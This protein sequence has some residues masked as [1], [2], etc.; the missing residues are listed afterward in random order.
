MLVR[1][2][3]PAYP[4]FRYAKRWP[5]VDPA[6]A[7]VA[8]GALFASL[9]IIGSIRDDTFMLS[10]PNVGLIQHPGIW[11]F[12][13]GQV[14]LPFLVR[15]AVR[16]FQKLPELPDKAL[17]AHYTKVRFASQLE[18]LGIWL[19][20][21]SNGSRIVYGLLTTLGACAWAWNTYSNQR[22]E[23]VGFDFWDSNRHLWGFSVT[24]FY[25]GYF[26]FG[27]LPCVAHIQIGLLF[28]MRRLIRDANRRRGLIME[29]YHSDGAGGLSVFIDTALNP[30]VPTVFIASM[31]SLSAV[32]VH[33]RYDITT[34]SGLTLACLA[35]ILMYLMPATTLRNAIKREKRRQLRKIARLQQKLY[36]EVTTP[37]TRD[38][39]L[40]VAES[41]E[42]IMGLTS[43][44]ERV[45]MLPEW[46]QL[47]R[48]FRLVVL[49][50]G[51]PVV[52]WAGEKGLTK[53]LAAGGM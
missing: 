8:I 35:F 28:A 12:L 47:H 7:N 25:K 53:L 43:V 3:L 14:W 16:Q 44:V 1:D 48:T 42:T 51:S 38:S 21:E 23:T 24:R 10:L 40:K 15:R 34:V 13:I 39:S 46:P 32:F 30:M 5:R 2:V 36:G 22:P 45:R 31:I 27:V 4:V 11:W 49:A 29:P 26:W 20:A 18:H 9:F 33:K 50:W 52:V 6:W 17:S 37:V 41:V 19:R